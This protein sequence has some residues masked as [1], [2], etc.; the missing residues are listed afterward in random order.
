[1]SRKQG[2]L[3]GVLAA[4]AAFVGWLAFHG[5]QAPVLPADE[6]HAAFVSPAECLTCHGPEAAVPRSP[7][8]PLGDECLRCHGSR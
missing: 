1:M 5:R 2:V 8:H 4:A 6:T 7:E 3:L